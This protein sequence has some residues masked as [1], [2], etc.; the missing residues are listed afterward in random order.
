[1]LES[2]LRPGQQEFRPGARLRRGV[3]ITDACIGWNE[4]VELLQELAEAA[5]EGAGGRPRR[6]PARAPVQGLRV[7]AGAA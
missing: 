4:T 2:N 5:A 3:S 6:R 7:R 1:M